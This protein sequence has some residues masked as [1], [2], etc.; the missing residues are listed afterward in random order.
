MAKQKELDAWFAW[1]EKERQK[2]RVMTV[3]EY[4]AWCRGGDCL[5]WSGST[6][7]GFR[8]LTITPGAPIIGQVIGGVA[9]P[10]FTK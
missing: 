5:G 6:N 7:P 1:R 9:P 10:T 2:D 3:G 4:Q 8:N